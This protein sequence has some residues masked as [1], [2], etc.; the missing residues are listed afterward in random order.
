MKHSIF[1]QILLVGCCAHAA[2]EALHAKFPHMLQAYPTMTPASARELLDLNEAAFD[3][4]A[5]LE[6]YISRN[7]EIDALRGNEINTEDAEQLL[8]IL[9][10]AYDELVQELP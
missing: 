4:N 5:L 9:G 1:W 7:R 3:Y 6:A 2:Q 10:D 8:N